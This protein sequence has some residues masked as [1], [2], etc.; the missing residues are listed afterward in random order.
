VNALTRNKAP[1]LLS[2]L[3]L[4]A[5]TGPA[6][7]GQLELALGLNPTM[8]QDPAYE[9]FSDTELSVA[10][11]GLDLRYEVADF[12]RG[13]RLAVLIGYRYARDEGNPLD[14]LDTQLQT[15]DFLAGLR[16]RAWVASW[17]GL[18]AELQGGLLWA[19]LTAEISESYWW[20]EAGARDRYQDDRLT[21]QAGGLAGVELRI[22]PA[23][24]ERRHVRRMGFGAEIGAGYLRRGELEFSPSLEG[25]DDLSLPRADPVSWGSVD[26]SGW[27]VQLAAVV[28]FH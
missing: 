14:V 16:L 10:R 26:L 23:F 24:L 5:M 18:F 21:W 4:L 12:G 17:A 8:I 1:A 13:L 25:G 11:A 28:T 27:F 22:S 19:D 2:A 9:A 3:A 7:A 15:H 6:G 20:A